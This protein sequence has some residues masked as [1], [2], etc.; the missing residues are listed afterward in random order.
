[1]PKTTNK[2]RVAVSARTPALL[3]LQLAETLKECDG[4]GTAAEF[5]AAMREALPDIKAEL[6]SRL[7]TLKK[8]RA[9]SEN[10]AAKSE[11]LREELDRLQAKEGK[12]RQDYVE[13]AGINAELSDLISQEQSREETCYEIERSIAQELQGFEG[14]LKNLILIFSN[15]AALSDARKS[16]SRFYNGEPVL[17]ADLSRLPIFRDARMKYGW[18]FQ[19]ITPADVQ[20]GLIT[21]AI[22]TALADVK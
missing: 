2:T 6:A 4:D 10:A 9:V 12:S 3:T 16:L 13:M 5:R 14:E 20:V 7:A 15:A 18:N 22:T 8:V 11:Q 17:D 21:K 1:M 19:F